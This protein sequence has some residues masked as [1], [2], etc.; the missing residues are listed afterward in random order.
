MSEFWDKRYS[1]GDYSYGTEPN[2]YF[3]ERLDL[4]LPGKLL[5][6]GEGEGRNAV[7]A[8]KRGWQVTA[9][10]L[11]SKGKEKALRLAA[12]NGVELDYHV[13]PIELFDFPASEFDA[14][15]LVFAH[16]PAETRT[17]IHRSIVNSIKKGGSLIIEAFSKKQI[18]NNS[19]GPKELSMLYDPEDLVRDFK[20]LDIIQ[21]SEETVELKEGKYH[22]GTADVI[23]ICGI[24]M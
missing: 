1:A 2:R 22:E 5:L 8:A 21:F 9:V 18:N 13:T 4:L 7:Y 23:R 14:A 6:P 17:M 3:K 10:D 12:E 19:G 16:F 11:S 20:N 15:A 24:R